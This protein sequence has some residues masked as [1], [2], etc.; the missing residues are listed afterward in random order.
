MILGKG[1]SFTSLDGD[2]ATAAKDL[3]TT[4]ADAQKAIKEG[5]GSYSGC[6]DAGTAKYDA[7]TVEY[8]QG[9]VTYDEGTVQTTID[10]VN[11]LVS[12]LLQH[13]ANAVA[14]Y[15][16]Q[17]QV[18]D[19]AN[20]RAVDTVISNANAAVKTWSSR[21]VSYTSQ[22]Q[23]LVDQANAAADAAEKAVCS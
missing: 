3:A 10:A 21:L 5:A 14:V 7:G 16:G 19:S 6:Y 23:Q 20:A 22:A 1:M 8:D 11:R 12:K 2:L 17:G 13:Y 9:T 15:A 4:K 18:I